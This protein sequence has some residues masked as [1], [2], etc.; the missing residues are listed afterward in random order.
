MTDILQEY[1]D[2]R[3]VAMRV[4]RPAGVIRGVKV[5]GLESRNGRSYLPEALAQAARLYE[6]AKVNVNHPRG[7][8]AAPR[9]YQDR[10]GSIRDV[11]MRPGEG[12]FADLHF[13][14]KHALAE[15]LIWDAEHAPENV[16]FSHNV[17]AR[18]SRRDGRLVVE[19]ITRVQSVDLVADPA[20]TRG[21]F[22]SQAATEAEATTEAKSE[23]PP[24]ADAVQEQSDELARLRREVERYQ[25]LEQQR[26][27]RE[28]IAALLIEFGLPNPAATDSLSKAVSSERFV[29][30]LLAVDDSTA[31]AMVEDRARLVR[32]LSGAKSRPQSVEQHVLA[33]AAPRD[34]KSFVEAI[35]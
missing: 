20:T 6:G 31:R 8:P 16:G 34:A 22:E 10:L 27:R 3:G 26:R 5:L 17:E 29:E 19:A 25:T 32:A 2:S 4:D 23:Q 1:C 15:Q 30:S 18:C 11:A 12:L 24:P 13:N 28:K 7:N 14:P 35:T 33:P 9:D 21:L